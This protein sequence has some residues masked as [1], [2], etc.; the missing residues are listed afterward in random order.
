VI[1]LEISA[2]IRKEDDWFVAK[3]LDLDVTTQGR[4]IEEAKSNLKEAIEL[5]IE[6]FGKDELLKSSKNEDLIYTRM[7]IAV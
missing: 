7:D 5:Y 4:T 2:I 6:S 1:I 3:C